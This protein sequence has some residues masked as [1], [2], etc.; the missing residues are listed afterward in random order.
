MRQLLIGLLVLCAAPLWAQTTPVPEKRVIVTRNVDFYGADLRSIFDTTLEACEKAC[1]NDAGCKAFTFNSNANACFPKSE[2]TSREPFAGAISAEIVATDPA[3]L[4]RAASR[5]TEL[6][7]L[8]ARD[9]EQAR[10]F[11]Q[12]M[13]RRHRPSDAT[14]EFMLSNAGQ[15]RVDDRHLDALRWTGA[16][17]SRTDRPEH[18]VDYARD[19]LNHAGSNS[20]QRRDY[21]NRA[22]LA[23]INAYLRADTSAQQGAALTE[24]ARALE[25]NGRGRDMVPTLS[26]ARVVAPG[27][28]IEAMLDDAIGKYGFR[29]VEHRVESDAASPRICA[30]FSESLEKSLDYAPY[31]RLPGVQVAV[32]STDREICVE[33]VDHGVR[34]GVTFRA[35]LPAADGQGL[36]KDTA[37]NLYVRDRSPSVR[38]PGRAYVLPRSAD[39]ALPIVTVN[40]PEVDL[41]IRRVSERNVLRIMQD[42]F[43]GRPLAA[44]QEQQFSNNL[45]EEVWSGT[46]VTGSDLNA[47]VT[48]RLPLGD[49]VSDLP[50]GLY[51]LQAKVPGSDP[52]ETPAATQWFVIS[53]LGV[54]TMNGTDGLHVFVRS[55]ASAEPK[56]G[57]TVTLLSRSNREIATATTDDKGYAMFGSALTLGS[58]SAAPG[59]LTVQDGTEDM[60][61]LSMTDPEFDL[62]DRGVE[63]RAPSGPIDVFLATDRGAYRAGETIFATALVRDTKADALEG[64]PL[65]A[66]LTR[67]DG[68]EYSRHV[69]TEDKAGGHVFALPIAGAVPRGTWTLRTYSDPDAPPLATKQVLVGSAKRSGAHLPGHRP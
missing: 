60:V 49:A 42:G 56:A 9:L 41:T 1:L 6:G 27:P 11:A 23:S 35:G 57:L 46:G 59:L 37:L 12:G 69:S 45:A 55:L 62:S 64:V 29:I 24:L 5:A 33:G 61:F 36:A 31:V 65:T 58:G 51:A 22:V 48:T 8:A 2:I 34:Y 7:F 28:Q 13:G 52:Y 54:A 47:D 21:Q 15:A 66:L 30:V 44:Y 38:F 25:A 4:Q 67:P 26:L 3:V 32:T 63:G 17:L 18:W 43:F 16:A 20:Q 40:T 19:A 14:V 68:V 50:A 39:A 53:D 10:D